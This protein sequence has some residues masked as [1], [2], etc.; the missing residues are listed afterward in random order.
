ME[1][2]QIQGDT[3]NGSAILHSVYANSFLKD[4]KASVRLKNLAYHILYFLNVI[5][6]IFLEI[7]PLFTSI[8]HTFF[9]PIFVII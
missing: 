7:S 6:I 9:I 5:Y 2:F 8:S 1:K 4:K 3:E